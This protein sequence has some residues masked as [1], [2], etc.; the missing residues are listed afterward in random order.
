ML[1]KE[2]RTVPL[3]DPIWN[4][5]LHLPSERLPINEIQVGL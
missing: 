1:K 5:T 4:P 2:T 3:L